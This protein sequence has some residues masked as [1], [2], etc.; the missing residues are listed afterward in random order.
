MKGGQIVLVDW[1]DALPGSA[2]PSKH[3]P[4]VVVGSPD[5]FDGTL[6]VEIVVPLTGERALAV[7]G[8]AILIPPTA[9]NGCT[10]TSFALAWNVQT[11]PHARLS[12]TRSSIT[13]DQLRA[14]RRQIA[15]CVGAR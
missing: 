1:R 7:P 9:D 3:R 10:K 13:D 15:D 8:G 4:G 2:E 14:I 11:V 5:F 12:E 6:P